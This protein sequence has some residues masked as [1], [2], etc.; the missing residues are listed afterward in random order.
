MTST[1]SSAGTE[2][3]TLDLRRHLRALEAGGELETVPGP[4]SIR[5]VARL[6]E[7]SERALLLERVQGY[8]MPVAANVMA[9]R[10][11]WALAFGCAESELREELG[12]RA[13]RLIPPVSVADGPVREVIEVGAAVDLTQL[14]AHLQHELDGGPYLSA[15][16]DVSRH[17]ES[18][19]HNLGM[20]RLMVRGPRETGVDLVAPSDL[21]ALYREARERGRRFEI[22]FVIGTHPLDYMASQMHDSAHDELHLAGGLRGAP[23]PVVPCA[24]VDLEV[25]ADAELVLEGCL[26]GDWTELEGPYG[27]FTGCYGAAH[28]NPVFKVTGLM[29]RRDAILQTATISGRRLHHTDTAMLGALTSELMIWHALRA[30][31]AEP[32]DVYCPTSAS[33]LL[34]ARVAIRRRDPGDGR[35]AVVAALAC[36]GVKMAVVVDED[37]DIRDDRAV[38][39]AI[40][41]RFQADR[42]LVVLEGMR[43]IPLDPSLPPHEGSMV[44]TSKMGIDATRRPD[45][46]AHLFSIPRAP[47]EGARPGAFGEGAEASAEEV[48]ERLERSLDRGPRFLDWLA[49]EP[50]LPQPVIV[51]ALGILRERGRLRLDRDGRHWP[52]EPAT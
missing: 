6:I 44:T 27:E 12:R 46:P 26:E 38:E 8:R 3:E 48:A 41:T 21:R 20:R 52:A 33:G 11:C 1:K 28:L 50:D 43:T 14:P 23:V 35:G 19:R 7:A 34:H 9:S 29:R 10:R 13:S 25:P 47:F 39:W 15:A 42:D 51:R 40:A 22:A 17:P 36:R 18:G 45:R 24:T 2:V 32:L 37:V 31:V 49:E 16:M 5:E 4:V 30:A